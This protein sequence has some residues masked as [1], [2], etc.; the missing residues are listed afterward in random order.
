M[1]NP[2]TGVFPCYKNQFAI[3]PAGDE[4][5]AMPIANCENFSVTFDNGVEEWHAFEDEGWVSRLMTAKSVKISIEAKRTIGDP[6]NDDVASLCMKSEHDVERNFI[7]NFPD[8]SSVLFKKA[9]I[10]VTDN[11]TGGTTNVAPLK[12]EVMSNGKPVYTPAA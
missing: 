3:G 11:G 6:G 9:P 8:G 12:I 4:T 7:W 2:V 1:P 5:P 10:S